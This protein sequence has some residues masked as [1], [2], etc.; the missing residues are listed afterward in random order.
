MKAHDVGT[1]LEKDEG[2]KYDTPSL[3]E[4]WRT[5]PYLCDGRA[6]TIMEVLTKFNPGDEHGKTSGLTER[7]LRDLEEYVMSQ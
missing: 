4:V 6:V 5:P 2:R 1:L 7:E 3:V